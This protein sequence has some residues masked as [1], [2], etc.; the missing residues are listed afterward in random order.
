MSRH[1]VVAIP[2]LIWI[3]CF[4]SFAQFKPDTLSLDMYPPEAASLMTYT[5]YPVS[6]MTG[7]PDIS[8]P[9]YTITPHP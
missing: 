3:N 6:Y 8:I 7:T 4:L 1:R 5:D 9:L 2:L